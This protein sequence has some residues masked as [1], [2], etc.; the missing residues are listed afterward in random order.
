[1][2][3]PMFL[4]NRAGAGDRSEDSRSFSERGEFAVP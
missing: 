3:Q 1:M 4:G 2:P